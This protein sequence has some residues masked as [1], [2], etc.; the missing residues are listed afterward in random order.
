MSMSM[1]MRVTKRT[2]GAEVRQ[3]KARLVDF[4]D[5]A[6]RGAVDGHGEANAS[7]HHEDLT[8]RHVHQAE[9]GAHVQN[10][11]LGNHL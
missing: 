2:D 5:I 10:A 3:D 8:G 9:L 11:L 6:A 7:L 4:A 1:S